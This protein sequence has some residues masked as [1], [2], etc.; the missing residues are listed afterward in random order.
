[1][2]ISVN[3]E[4][5][6]R[7]R[8][9]YLNHWEIPVRRP[10]D[11]LNAPSATP[12]YLSTPYCGNAKKLTTRVWTW[13]WERNNGSTG[14]KVWKRKLTTQKKSDCTTGYRNGENNQKVSKIIAKRKRTNQ[15][16]DENEERRRKTKDVL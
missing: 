7:E 10:E 4:A 11:D 9:R 3:E 13:T 6:R 12:I 15:D 16:D 8:R 2:R 5:E 14:K 1:V